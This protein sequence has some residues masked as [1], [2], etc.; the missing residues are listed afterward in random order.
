[1]ASSGESGFSTA[2]WWDAE[3]IERRGGQPAEPVRSTEQT[4]A[5]SDGVIGECTQGA[6]TPKKVEP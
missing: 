1:M 2:M 3:G 5:R 4:L 6:V